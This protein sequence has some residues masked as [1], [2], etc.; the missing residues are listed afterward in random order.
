MKLTQ[1]QMTERY[2]ELSDLIKNAEEEFEQLKATIK[3]GLLA[4]KTYATD[5]IQLK[6]QPGSTS[7]YDTK[8]MLADKVIKPEVLEQYKRVTT[9]DKIEKVKIAAKK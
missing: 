3:T 8:Q 5:T 6:L 2:L 7:R 9:Y 1:R 4:R